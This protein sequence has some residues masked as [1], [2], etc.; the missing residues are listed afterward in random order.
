MSISAA[1][2]EEAVGIVA[3]G[4]LDRKRLDAM[5][6]QAAREWMAGALSTTVGIGVESQIDGARGAVA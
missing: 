2:D 1:G 3:S 4:Q 5:G 6:P